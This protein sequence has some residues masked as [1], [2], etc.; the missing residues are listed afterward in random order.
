MVAGYRSRF[1]EIYGS[2]ILPAL[3]QIEKVRVRR[4]IRILCIEFIALLA[5]I[6]LA[7]VGFFNGV[8]FKAPVIIEEYFPIYIFSVIGIALGLPAFEQARFKSTLKNSCMTDIMSAFE[9]ITWVPSPLNSGFLNHY[10]KTLYSDV[11]INI[12]ATNLFSINGY[13][14]YN[15][16][17]YDDI[18]TGEYNKVRFTIAETELRYISGSGKNKT[19]KLIFNGALITFPSNKV[20]KADTIIKPKNNDYIGLN[21]KL[22]IIIP[23]AGAL[24]FALIGIISKEYIFT[25]FASIWLVLWAI[26]SRYIPRNN[27]NFEKINLEDV[28]F[29]KDYSVISE[30]QIEAR[31]LLTAAFI[32]RFKRLQKVYKTKSIRCSFYQNQ[33]SF[34]IWSSRDMFEIGD[35][36]HSLLDSRKAQEFF[37]EMTAVLDMIELFRL[38]EKTG[39]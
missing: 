5:L 13:Q 33:I 26:F 16:E 2:R 27:K 14:E 9:N 30:D 35:L 20:I 15:T 12:P 23:I 25:V 31:Y 24:S 32:D 4:Y 37:E 28:D 21:H 36:W 6:Y 39:L 8:F 3:Q 11:A 34:A 7:C 38:D 1:Y 10:N 29:A 17:R 22:N 19:N 18:F